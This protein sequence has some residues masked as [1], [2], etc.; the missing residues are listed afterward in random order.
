M[1]E[2]EC[3]SEFEFTKYTPYLALTGEVKVVFSGDL[4]KIDSVITAPQCIC[5]QFVF[6][7]VLLWFVT[8]WFCP[9]FSR[10]RPWHRGYLNQ[11]LS[12]ITTVRGKQPWPV[13]V[14]INSR[15]PLLAACPESVRVRVNKTYKSSSNWWYNTARNGGNILGYFAGWRRCTLKNR[16]F[17]KFV[18]IGGTVNCRL[19]QKT[20]FIVPVESAGADRV[21]IVPEGSGSQRHHEQWWQA[22]QIDDL[23]F[24]SSEN[25]DLGLFY[26]IHILTV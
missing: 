10:L 19:Y 24:S 7:C 13:W 21:L 4:G 23:L 20:R 12:K 16:Q 22:C 26:V 5:I 25:N 3:K 1:T 17:V 14:N 2:V 15:S 9:Y 6:Y 11:C 8:G 18:I